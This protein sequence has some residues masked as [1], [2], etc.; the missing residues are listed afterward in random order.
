MEYLI[1]GEEYR[2]DG[3]FTVSWSP[4]AKADKYEIVTKVP[5]V[6]G[7]AELYY[8]DL[9]GK[10][11][12]FCLQRSWYGGVR[13]MIRERCDASLEKDPYRLSVLVKWRDRL[14]YRYSRS[15]SAP[16]MADVMFFFM[17]TY[18]P[19]SGVCEHSGRYNRIF[20]KEIDTGKL[21][22]T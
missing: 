18:S 17:E 19:G 10:L 6:G 20:L 7:I 3:Y 5:A 2:G 13:S 8:M 11:N 9:E 22:T 14:Y 1:K 21:T 4:F 12:L 15:E 16:D